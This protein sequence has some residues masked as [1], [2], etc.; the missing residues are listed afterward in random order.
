MR[1]LKRVRMSLRPAE[2]QIQWEAIGRRVESHPAY[3][4]FAVGLLDILGP[5]EAG[6]QG[7]PAGGKY[8]GQP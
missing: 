4:S 7:Y 5:A 3:F 8:P 6:R 1:G 2:E